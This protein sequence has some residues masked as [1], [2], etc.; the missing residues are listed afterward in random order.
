MKPENWNQ[1]VSVNVK[2]IKICAMVKIYSA[3]IL[4]FMLLISSNLVA[5]YTLKGVVTD[6]QTNE[7][8][9]GVMVF[10]KGTAGST[11]TNKGGMFGISNSD[12]ILNLLITHIGYLPL[13]L[14]LNTSKSINI[15]L[16]KGSFRL[17]DVVLTS[18]INGAY[19][20]SIAKT[21]LNLRPVNSSQE[22]LKTVP[23]LFIAQHAGGG[24]AEQIFL[25]GFDIDHG[26]D[27]QVSV[28]GLPVNMVSHGHGQG[29]A[30]LH[31]LIPELVKNIDYGKGP[32]YSEHGNLNTAGY[33][34]FQT[35]N[36]LEK[37]RL[38]IERG[39]FNHL[40][41]LAMVNLLSKKQTRQSAFVAAEYLQFD[42][43]FQSPQ[44]FNRVNIFCKYINQLSSN[45]KLTFIT[46]AFSSK[47]DASGQ[48]PQRAI[49]DKITGR[50]GAIDNT[51]G[52]YTGRYNTSVQLTSSF[53]N[54]HSFESQL[55]YSR[56]YFQLFSNFTFF[57]RDSVNGDQIRQSDERD[58]VGF[59][60]KYS[61]PF[62]IGNTNLK[63][64]FGATL[65]HDKTY[66][67]ELAY[68]KQRIFL[69]QV[70]QGDI[71]ES[72][73]ALFVD[74][75]IHYKKW[76]IDFGGRIDY[77]HFNY[78]D[79]LNPVQAP[80]Q[81][82]AIVSP[83]LNVH[84]TFNKKVQA[85]LKTGKGFHS[86]DTRV[87]VANDGNQILPPAF[88]ADAGVNFHPSQNLVINTAIWYL[89][90]QQE[91]VYVGDE[92]VIE[93]S[94]RS[95]RLGI[96]VAARYQFNKY[97]FADGNLNIA[98]ARFIDNDKTEN[99]IPLAPL[100]TSTGGISYVNKNGFNGSVRYRY[101]KDRPANETN[102][103]IAKGYFLMD[104]VIN[105]TRNKYEIGISAENLLN[106]QWNEAQFDTESRLKNE[107]VPVSEIH[108][109]PGT[110]FV[111]KLKLAITL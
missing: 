98:S 9:E 85:F 71:T 105:Y 80:S 21:D 31:F 97:L 8:L 26:T 99:K 74:Q 18:N 28:D 84:Y 78:L 1:I 59:N 44:N 14:T 60:S 34:S 110:P 12:T 79:K 104:A 38:Q 61:I 17:Q 13:D 65:R 66:D 108:F 2:E 46:S 47:W 102:S 95:K 81:N 70:K 93:P 73:A 54:G 5:Q 96:D 56:Y 27:V 111:A 103:V 19:F 33:V 40:R 64:T 6:S 75:K 43:P 7:A 53:K 36:Q 72:N 94:G 68:T 89:Y 37:N 45:T 52:G 50:F 25:R 35:I 67:T 22:L 39:Q 63:T 100:F 77:L 106:A 16:V 76:L 88:G 101:I 83:K 107:Q 48:L 41:T 55:F 24:K 109:T 42:G 30:D 10:L 23:G 15:K 91:F 87:V 32:Y 51:E 69:E 20:S 90:L 58:I 11:F 29:Y 4:I 3:A 86:N 49:D 57:L 82:K 62:S 92:G